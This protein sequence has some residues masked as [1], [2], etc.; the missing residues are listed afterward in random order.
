VH[1]VDVQR[2]L[3]HASL[4]FVFDDTPK[5]QRLASAAAAAPFR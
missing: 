5:H 4:P 1:S 2:E 3:R